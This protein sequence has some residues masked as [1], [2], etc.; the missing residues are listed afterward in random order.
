MELRRT[1][2]RVTDIDEVFTIFFTLK[3]KYAYDDALVA[4]AESTRKKH[5]AELIYDKSY[6]EYL[7]GDKKEMWKVMEELA[8]G[9]GLEQMLLHICRACS[10]LWY[11]SEPAT[12]RSQCRGLGFGR[13]GRTTVRMTWVKRGASH[14]H[15]A[16]S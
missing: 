12:H 15:I 11:G 10:K 8:P 4:L 14:E 3:L 13:T 5:L 6:R 2:E 9:A 16:E 1:V 7:D